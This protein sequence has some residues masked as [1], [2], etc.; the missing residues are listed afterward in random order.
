[1][2]AFVS[3]LHRSFVGALNFIHPWLWQP[4][5]VTRHVMAWWYVSGSS[6]SFTVVMLT[7]FSGASYPAQLSG[8]TWALFSIEAG[9]MLNVE[10]KHKQP[11][12]TR[13]S[14]LAPQLTLS[15]DAHNLY[16]PVGDALIE[17]T[18]K[19]TKVWK[20]G[21]PESECFA[22]RRQM[23]NR[24]KQLMAKWQTCFQSFVSSRNLWAYE[25]LEG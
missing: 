25:L 9:L 23:V 13:G 18:W 20:V 8:S 7:C 15:F 4:E 22:G 16:V 5:D 1:M 24:C 10:R 6:G 21:M 12:Q 3:L 19:S 2:S 14:F 17:R 11:P